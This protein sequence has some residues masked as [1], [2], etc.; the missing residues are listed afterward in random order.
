MWSER[1]GLETYW[2]L[3]RLFNE[4]RE[5][6]ICNCSPLVAPTVFDSIKLPVAVITD[7][8]RIQSG[9]TDLS[10]W[11]KF[12]RGCPGPTGIGCPQGRGMIDFFEVP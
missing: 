3:Y 10:Q 6:F 11:R 8:N 9:Y 2:N 12:G 7:I 5:C 4:N 1:V